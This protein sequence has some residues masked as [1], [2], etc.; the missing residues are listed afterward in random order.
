MTV[1]LGVAAVFIAAGLTSCTPARNDHQRSDQIS[2]LAMNGPG[3]RR[4]TGSSL[5]AVDASSIDD[6]WVLGYDYVGRARR[7]FILHWDGSTWK[8]MGGP[9][10]GQVAVLSP[11]DAWGVGGDI[12]QARI[13]HWDGASWTEMAHR[14]PPG[15][16]FS[17]IDALSPDDVWVVGHKYGPEYAPNTRG[18]ATVIEHWDGTAW[19]VVPSPNQ[20]ANDN[21]LM[22]VTAVSPSDVW[23]SGFTEVTSGVTNTL[24]LHWNG[25]RWAIVPSPPGVI[26]DGRRS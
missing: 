9:P 13:F 18:W 21:S 2:R 19:S 17:A 23:A 4:V 14:D 26:L 15:A 5:W 1:R 6:V 11:T 22:G 24:T 3:A 7:S 10:I 12:G 8:R 16:S 25:K 20:H